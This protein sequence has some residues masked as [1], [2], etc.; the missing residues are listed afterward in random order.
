MIVL[1]YLRNE[2]QRFQ[3]FLA[4]RVAMIRNVSSPTQWRHVPS[5]ANPVND[6]SRGLT[7]RNL[8]ESQCLICGPDFLWDSEAL[9]PR[10]PDFNSYI[11]ENEEVEKEP[12]AYHVISEAEDIVNSLFEMFSDWYQLNKAVAWILRLKKTLQQEQQNCCFL[13]V[14]YQ[15]TCC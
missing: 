10:Q 12:Q 8:V 2:E 7:T 11:P 14:R 1:H 15:S 3:T 5:E 13:M 9:W 4:N 6:V